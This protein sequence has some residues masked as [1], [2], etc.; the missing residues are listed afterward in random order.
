M[1]R[2]LIRMFRFQDWR[3]CS[4]VKI[5]AALAEDTGSVSSTHIRQLINACNASSGEYHL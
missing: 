1:E 4:V 3:D 2:T 5:H